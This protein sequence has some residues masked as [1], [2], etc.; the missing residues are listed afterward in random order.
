MSN[1]QGPD[2]DTESAAER[3]GELPAWG[4]PPPGGWGAGGDPEPEA[5]DGWAAQGARDTGWDPAA[6]R[7]DATRD[8]GRPGDPASTGA[9]SPQDTG[10]WS[11][12]DTGSWSR[13][14]DGGW[15]PQQTGGWSP[16]PR[17]GDQ[18]PREATGAWSPHQ[19]GGWGGPPHGGAGGPAPAQTSGGWDQ[20]WDQGGQAA[21]VWGDDAHGENEDTW[22]VPTGRRARR[23]AAEET[24]GAVPASSPGSAWNDGQQ[25]AAQPDDAWGEGNWDDPAAG[26]EP[27]AARED[28]GKRRRSLGGNRM[29]ILIAAGVLVAAV[30]AVTAFVWPGWALTTHLDRTALQTGVGQVLSEDYGL[31]VGAVQCP[32][33]VVVSAGTEFSCQ[34]VVDGEQ[35]EVPGIVTSDE[36]DYQVNR[37]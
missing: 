32:D 15:S 23:R 21:P 36:G 28:G 35:V 25:G 16:Q 7:R 13:Q 22:A 1:P 31:E 18:D 14:D 19:D 8:A 29:W 9:W 12:K 37:V 11:P 34:A 5:P 2:R 30:L 33:D 4:S 24:G 6:A 10:A 26:E 27:W 20:G 3:T 17:A